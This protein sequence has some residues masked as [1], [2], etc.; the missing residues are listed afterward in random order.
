MR[1]SVCQG[2]APIRMAGLLVIGSVLSGGGAAFLDRHLRLMYL[3]GVLHRASRTE[4]LDGTVTETFTNTPIKCQ[5]DIADEKMRQAAGYTDTDMRVLVL[6]ADIDRVN[7]DDQVTDGR[8]DR[9]MIARASLDPC[10]AYW[11]CHGQRV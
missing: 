6:A 1:V 8:G 7:T 4:A 5:T 2:L 3:D 9:W 11:D 10:G